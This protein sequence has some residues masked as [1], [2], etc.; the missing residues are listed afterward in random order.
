[1]EERTY[2]QSGWGLRFVLVLVFAAI[3]VQVW[4]L[5]TPGSMSHMV[6]VVSAVLLGFTLVFF[7]SIKVTLTGDKLVVSMGPGLVR[8]TL[9]ISDIQSVSFTK[10]PW[11]SVGLKRIYKGWLY[12]V[13]VTDAL[14][15]RMVDGKRYI[16]GIKDAKAIGEILQDR[17]KITPSNK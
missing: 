14:D 7:T 2:S 6:L 3:A 1:M 4:A 17:M 15:I 8:R 12:S 16:I 9:P 13:G 5:K 11:H 10:V